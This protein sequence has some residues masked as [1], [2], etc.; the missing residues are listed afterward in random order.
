MKALLFLILSLL[1]TISSPAQIVTRKESI[2]SLYL[3]TFIDTTKLSVA[4]GFIVKSKTQNY[5]ITNWHVVSEK[6]PVTQ[7]WIDSSSRRQPNRIA[8]VHN[9]KQLGTHVIK[10]ETLVDANGVR[11]YEQFKIDREMVDVIALPLKD[12]TGI[13]IYPVNYRNVPDSGS[14]SPTD[15]LF[16]VGFPLGIYGSSSLPIWKSGLI[17]S[18]P[19]TDQENKPIIWVDGVG[20]L[21]MSG[22][23]VYYI[24]DK[25]PTRPGIRTRTPNTSPSLFTGVY[26]HL[27][28]MGKVGLGALWKGPFLKFLFDRLP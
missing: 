11:Q 17:A 23:P 6:N 2:Q 12:T 18:E 8:I 9:G 25:I 21:G 4:T 22:A 13:T 15:R 5:L 14:L 24:D 28:F 10:Y 26:S 3:A 19:D 27:P 20:Y 16:I 7:N 1:A